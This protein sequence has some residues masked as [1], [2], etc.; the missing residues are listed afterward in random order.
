VLAGVESAVADAV[1]AVTPLASSVLAASAPASAAAAAPAAMDVGS[2]AEHDI[3]RQ[4]SLSMDSWQ[5]E[6]IR[7]AVLHWIGASNQPVSARES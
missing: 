5:N 4:R 6:A 1:A 2:K 3:L 7:L